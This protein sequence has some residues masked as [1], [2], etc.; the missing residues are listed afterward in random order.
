[1]IDLGEVAEVVRTQP[2]LLPF[3]VLEQRSNAT[4]IQAGRQ[5]RHIFRWSPHLFVFVFGRGV[6]NG[7]TSKGGW[8]GVRGT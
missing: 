8:K 3:W 4:R 2:P 5:P 1:M 7:G 6:G